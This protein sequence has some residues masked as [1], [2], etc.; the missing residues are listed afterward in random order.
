[1]YEQRFIRDLF[2]CAVASV[3]HYDKMIILP[4]DVIHPGIPAVHLLYTHEGGA[5]PQ[6]L[7][8]I[9]ADRAIKL[10]QSEAGNCHS[11]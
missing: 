5:E 7:Q 8:P 6:V 11:F 1:L 4:D 9:S 2:L 3:S 10:E